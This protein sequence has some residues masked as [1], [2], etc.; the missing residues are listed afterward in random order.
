MTTMR[1]DNS[2]YHLKHLFIGAEGT[3][4]IITECALLC[5]PLAKN[6]HLAMLACDSIDNCLEILKITRQKFGSNLSAFEFLDGQTA[7][8]CKNE[9]PEHAKTPF[10]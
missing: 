10:S 4:G 2:G 1:K 7:D 9:F 8:L 5:K 3:L 6:R